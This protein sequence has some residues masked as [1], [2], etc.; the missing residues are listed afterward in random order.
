M[1]PYNELEYILSLDVKDADKYRKVFIEL[2]GQM[3]MRACIGANR[4]VVDAMN[5]AANLA[6]GDILI[7]VSD[8][9]ESFSNW[10]LA[11]QEAVTGDDWFLMVDD[12][13]QKN[14]ATLLIVSRKYYRRFGYLYYPEYKSMW[15]DNDATEVAK[16]LGK[17]QEAFHL[18]FK[19]NH[20]SIGGIGA[21]GTTAR[22][23]N[24]ETWSHGENLFREREARGFDI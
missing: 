17:Y 22:H 5:R 8:D 3:G 7:Y 1:S 19:H 21:D 12:G 15:G 6:T 16:C 24:S 18:L 11:L 2:M 10:D 14:V 4:N 23:E 20:H 9:F 13:I